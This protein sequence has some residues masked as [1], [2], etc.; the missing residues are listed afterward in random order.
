MKFAALLAFRFGIVFARVSELSRSFNS[1][2]VGDRALAIP[3]L[4]QFAVG[5]DVMTNFGSI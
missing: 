5:I 3:K 4:E 2:T 1:V